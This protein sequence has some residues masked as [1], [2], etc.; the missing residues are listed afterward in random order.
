MKDSSNIIKG[1]I[2]I[3]LGLFILFLVFNMLFGIIP[4]PEGSGV[5]Y[6]ITTLI[7]VVSWAGIFDSLD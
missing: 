6:L 4:I 3:G 1:M 2:L 5:L 7:M